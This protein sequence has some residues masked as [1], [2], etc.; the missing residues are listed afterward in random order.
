MRRHYWHIALTG[1]DAHEGLSALFYAWGPAQGL[2]DVEG[3]VFPGVLPA[4][5]DPVE[6]PGHQSHRAA[7]AG[8]CRIDAR[9]TT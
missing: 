2:I 8:C 1:T 9:E 5:R 3:F 4:Y 7:S 6:V